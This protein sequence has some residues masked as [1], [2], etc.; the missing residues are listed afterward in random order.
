M[1]VVCSGKIGASYASNG[2]PEILGR[3]R[4]ADAEGHGKPP[5][6]VRTTIYTQLRTFGNSEGWK[7]SVHRAIAFAAGVPL[8]HDVL[9]HEICTYLRSMETMFGSWIELRFPDYASYVDEMSK[10]GAYGDDITLMAAAA[11][12]LRPVW[13]V[14]PDTESHE[15]IR[16][17]NPPT[18]VSVEAWGHPIVLGFVDWCH[19]EA[20]CPLESRPPLEAEKKVVKAE[21]RWAKKQKV[22]NLIFALLNPWYNSIER[23]S[24][25][26]M[27]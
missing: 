7:L 6:G 3:V 2:L 22:C 5:Q 24:R 1:V 10:C 15:G 14:G 27:I 18:N 19:Y 12:F 25:Y 26:K 4:R 16:K 11:L 23:I 20:T 21:P 17:F 13:V 8:T 9:R